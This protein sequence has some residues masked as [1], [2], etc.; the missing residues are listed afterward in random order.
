ME[1]RVDGKP[2]LRRHRRPAV[3]PGQP[4]VVIIHGA[5]M[6][7][8]VWALQARSLAHRGRSVLALDLP[9]HG[10]SRGAG[11]AEHRRD[12]GLADPLPRCRGH[13]AGRALS[14]IAWARSLRWR[15]RPAAPER[16]RRLALL[17]VAARMPVHPDLLAA[18]KADPDA[19]GR[20][21]RLLGPWAGGPFRRPA[22]AGPLA[23]WAGRRAAGARRGRACWPAIS[24]PATAMTRRAVAAQVACPALLLL[25]AR[26]A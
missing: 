22:G 21:H 24:R 3:R 14:A 12:G 15:Q 1:L 17:G 7:H 5:G 26:T 20:S 10:R 25:G 9:G 23:A 18:A 2:G 16:V 13:P 8:T 6:D 19:G 4:A 11:A